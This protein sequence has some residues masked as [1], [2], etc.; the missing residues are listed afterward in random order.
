VALKLTRW[1]RDR[2]PTGTMSMIDHLDELRTRLI[3]SIG[4]I[5]LGMI[6]GWFLFRPV[7]NIMSH[8]FCDFM[9]AHPKLAIRPNDPCRLVY[10]SVT[11]PFVIKLKVVAFLGITLALPI[12]LY[13][14]WRFVTPG[15]TQRERRYAI[16]FVLSSLALF[17]MGGFFAML[18]L[19]KGLGF[20]LGFAG[21]SNITAVLTIGKYLGF[22]ML[23]ILAFG[24]AFEFPLILIALMLVGVLSSRQLRSWRRYA[25]VAIAVIAAVITPSQDWFTMSALM[26]PLLIFYELSILVGRILKK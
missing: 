23:V 7:F 12:I 11:E 3:T 2:D 13:Q 10:T 8:P 6:G 5:A 9:S 26:I 15:L 18:T 1:R 22:V 4:A 14:F 25:I 21:T 16:P 19:P 17:T 20:L 24:A